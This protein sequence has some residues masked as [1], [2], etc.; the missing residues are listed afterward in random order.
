M[1]TLEGLTGA[2]SDPQLVL[3]AGEIVKMY[4]AAKLEFSNGTVRVWT[5]V[6]D[7]TFGPDTFNGIANLGEIS[8]IEETAEL[9]A[10]SIS[11]SL[12]G[13]PNGV[14]PAA[15]SGR[16]H[17]RKATLWLGGES[18]ID[19]TRLLATNDDPDLLQVGE[20]GSVLATQKGALIPWRIVLF[21]GRM[22]AVSLDEG[23][24]TSKLSITVESSLSKLE[25][26]ATARYTD[27]YQQSVYPGD[28][29]FEFVDALQHTNIA[30][31]AKGNALPSAFL[32]P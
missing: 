6:G 14:L 12:S 32:E 25:R 20:H 11:L 13:I 19:Q 27:Q 4:N 30:W 16:A 28:K 18:L 21:R 26:L 3:G 31:G 5:G 29:G 8:P 7:L 24:E 17:G 23:A 15:I 9:K 10:G 2:I 1:R 22:D